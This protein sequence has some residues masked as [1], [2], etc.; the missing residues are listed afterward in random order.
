MGFIWLNPQQNKKKRKRAGSEN[1][2]GINK[3]C[4]CVR[5][6]FR[7]RSGRNLFHL[8]EVKLMRYFWT[9]FRTSDSF[10]PSL[11]FRDLSVSEEKRN[12][13][14]KTCYRIKQD[15]QTRKCLPALKQYRLSS[16][17]LHWSLVGSG[18]WGNSSPPFDASETCILPAVC[19]R[20][21]KRFVRVLLGMGRMIR[22]T[23]E[24]EFIF[25]GRAKGE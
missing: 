2:S 17:L 24:F 19:L 8:Q 1:E 22:E 11:I 18:E 16:G 13:E 15:R 7:C 4:V 20:K 23:D 14:A 6:E 3:L 12:Q 9:I 21:E 10:F 25:V 5:N